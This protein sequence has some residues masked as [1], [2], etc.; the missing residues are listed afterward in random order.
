MHIYLDKWTLYILGGIGIALISIFLFYFFKW[1]HKLEQKNKRMT[2]Q[3][4]LDCSHL[5]IKDGRFGKKFYFVT[6]LNKYQNSRQ[7]ITHAQFLAYKEKG[8][9]VR[10]IKGILHNPKM[11]IEL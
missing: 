4:V 3:E 5:L 6:P 9:E 11:N 7:P 1:V 10:G 2:T 8:V